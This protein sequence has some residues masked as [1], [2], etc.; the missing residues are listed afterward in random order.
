MDKSN[1]LPTVQQAQQQH[2]LT[3]TKENYISN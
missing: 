3:L 2:N 1:D